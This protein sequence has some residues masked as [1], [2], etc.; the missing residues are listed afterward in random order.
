MQLAPLPIIAMLIMIASLA[1]LFAFNAPLTALVFSL[2]AIFTLILEIIDRL[3][4][5]NE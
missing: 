2:V 1:S 4:N 5:D 3:G